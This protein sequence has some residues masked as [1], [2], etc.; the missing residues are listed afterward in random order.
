MN[1]INLISIKIWWEEAN[2]VADT[3]DWVSTCEFG[4]TLKN[5]ESKWNQNSKERE[6]KR[7]RVNYIE[8]EEMNNVFWVEIL[9]N[10]FAGKLAFKSCKL[11]RHQLHF[12]VK[13]ESGYDRHKKE[14]EDTKA[15]KMEML[16]WMCYA[17][18]FHS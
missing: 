13:I 2:W 1:E 12:K 16:V 18:E 10:L 5:Y 4:K 17:D 6:R 8:N 7:E 14:E 3:V 15:K 11:N 9:S